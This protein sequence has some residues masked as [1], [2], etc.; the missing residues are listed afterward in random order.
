MRLF[1]LWQ[2]L[3]VDTLLKSRENIVKAKVVVYDTQPGRK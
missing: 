2:T 1:P 3:Y